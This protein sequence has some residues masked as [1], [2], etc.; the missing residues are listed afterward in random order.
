MSDSPDRQQR[1][2]EDARRQF[3]AARANSDARRKLTELRDRASSRPALFAADARHDAPPPVVLNGYDVL[4]EVHRGGQGVVYEALQRSTGRR[5]AVKVLR[6]G[7][8]SARADLLRF[9]REV[10]ILAQF[11]HPNIVGIV[12]SGVSAGHSYFVMDFIDGRPLDRWML[13]IRNRF[14]HDPDARTAIRDALLVFAKICDAVHAAHLRGVIHRDLKP[15]NIRIDPEGEPHVLDFGLAKLASESAIDASRNDAMTQTGQF[16]GSIPWASPEQARGGSADVDVR[17]DVYSLGIILYQTLTGRFP[18]EVTGSLPDVLAR[19][20]NA[21]PAPP[22]ALLRQDDARSFAV[23]DDELD[24]ISLKCL[25]KEPDRRYQSAGEL[26]RDLRHYLAGEPIEAKRDS[27]AYMAR[28][29]LS[30]YRAQLIV[31]AAFLV[32]LAAGLV[33]SLLFWRSAA[34]EARRASIEADKALAFGHEATREAQRAKSMSDHAEIEARRANSEAQK[35]KQFGDFLKSILQSVD[36]E[37]ARGRDTAILRDVLDAAARKIDAHEIADPQVEAELRDVLGDVYEKIGEYEAAEK[38]FRAALD[39]Q[40][41]R[42]GEIDQATVRAAGRLAGVLNDLGRSDEAADL[43][44]RYEAAARALPEKSE[45]RMNLLVNYALALDDQRRSPEAEPILREV[46]ENAIGNDEKYE[47][48]VGNNLAVCLVHQ[49]KFAEAEP[50]FR[51]ALDFNAR[52][53]GPDHVRTLATQ[54]NISVVLSELD[55]VKEA[56]PLSMDALERARAI[57]GENHPETIK[58]MLVAGSQLLALGRLDEAE[59]IMRDAIQR[60]RVV[61][62]PKNPELYRSVNQLGMILQSQERHVEAELTLREAVSLATEMRGPDD[63]MTASAEI[64]LGLLY[65]RLGRHDEAIRLLRHG[66]EV[67]RARLAADTPETAQSANNLALALTSAGLF[68]EAI[69]LYRES[70][71]IVR[72]LLPPE[73]P[74]ISYPLGGLFKALCKAGRYAEAEPLGR[75]YLERE[76]RLG[77]TDTQEILLLYG[78]TLTAVGKFAEARQILLD[79]EVR[80]ARVAPQSAELHDTRLALARLYKAWN[81]AEPSDENVRQSEY[82]RTT[83]STDPVQTPDPPPTSNSADPS[84]E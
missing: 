57:L 82:W 84:G 63:P 38:H 72:R 75:E 67:R 44:R 64:N 6:E 39:F 35:A 26:A 31:G 65:N 4:R 5:V 41:D 81:D 30:R 45:H 62:G 43:G 76:A 46:L 3:E 13:E 79:L 32:V 59:G 15:S 21:D 14:A 80:T 1:V 11:Q 42:V 77:N 71:S 25:Q 74:V 19:I 37:T 27:F 8:L 20:L 18:Y 56:L 70:L 69:P 61:L 12:D 60:G 23:A 10:Q 22:S 17:T 2:I 49:G 52:R 51:R 78:E 83:A 29:Q 50:L 34:H 28:K 68:D 47:V 36:P 73:H 9:E 7:P 54:R 55:R 66:H 48:T 33:A 58:S 24:T 40:R 16:L 53:F